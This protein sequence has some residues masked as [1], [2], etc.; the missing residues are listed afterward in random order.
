MIVTKN[1]ET[2]PETLEEWIEIQVSLF[3]PTPKIMRTQRTLPLY[4]LRSFNATQYHTRSV[5][6]ALG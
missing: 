3:T 1:G 5:R 2:L 4:L 6:I